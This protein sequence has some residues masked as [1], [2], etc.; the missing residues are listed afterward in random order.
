MRGSWTKYE[1]GV[2]KDWENIYNSIPLFDYTEADEIQRSTERVLL[3]EAQLCIFNKLLVGYI[4]GKIVGIFAFN[5]CLKVEHQSIK[6]GQ[7]FLFHPIN[8]QNVK[9]YLNFLEERVVK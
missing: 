6:R 8:F 9:E 7:L 3:L 1:L 2:L 5:E 4:E